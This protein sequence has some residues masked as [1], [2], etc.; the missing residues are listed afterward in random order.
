[1]KFVKLVELIP[2]AKLVK[3]ILQFVNVNKTMSEIHF[4]DVDVN[5]NLQETVLNPKNVKDSNAY[6]YVEKEFVAKMPTVK[7]E[8][9]EPNVL[10]HQISSVTDTL[11]A[12]LNVQ[13]TTIV[14]E[15]KPVLNSNVETHAENQIQMY[16][17]KEQTAK[18]KIIS[19]FAHVQ[20]DTPVIHSEAAV[21]L[22]EKIFVN[23]THVEM[24]PNAS[25]AMIVVAL[26]DQS[27]H[28]HQEQEGI[29]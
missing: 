29:L 25:L 11:D 2:I 9:T 28:V 15:T 12:T 20:E 8:I 13:S 10:A 5:V 19:Q 14:L 6:R 1:M 4:K 17:A 27:A 16:A 7:L 23:L 3:T 22:P 18:S 26:T 21:S 24:E